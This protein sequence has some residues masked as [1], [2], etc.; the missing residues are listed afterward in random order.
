MEKVIPAGI[1]LVL[2]FV[3]VI[4]FSCGEKK[5]NNTTNDQIQDTVGID[6]V[7]NP[8]PDEE[9]A[10]AAEIFEYRSESLKNY[11]LYAIYLF[12]DAPQF[13]IVRNDEARLLVLNEDREVEEGQAL[14]DEEFI[15]AKFLEETET[16]GI[17][18]FGQIELTTRADL[19]ITFN[20]SQIK[21]ALTIGGQ[22]SDTSGDG[23]GY[24]ALAPHGDEYI[25]AIGTNKGDH[26]CE[27]ESRVRIKGNIAYFQ[28]KLS[29]ENCKLIFF[30]TDR[31]VQV[32]Q[33]S[34]N[35]D[36]GCGAKASLN[37][38]FVMK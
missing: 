4:N 15:A 7:S 33:V 27:L 3:L 8:I 36:C 16:E 24:F 28:G 20:H 18:T 30:F 17:T 22:Y 11:Q 12:Q 1:R 29:A 14:D 5:Q 37:H 32:L 6:S 38:Q 31:K 10:Y 34:S 26:V 23:S 2:L 19:N 13:V 21:R 9:P 25:I 35:S